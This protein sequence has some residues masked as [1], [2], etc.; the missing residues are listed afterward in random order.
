MNIDFN[1]L[2]KIVEKCVKDKRYSVYINNLNQVIPLCEEIINKKELL[3]VET[4]E[5][6]T[7]YDL[8]KKIELVSS[9]FGTLDTNLKNQFDNLV[10]S[11][12]EDR[13]PT[14]R[15][16]S[17]DMNYAE[18]GKA[19]IK[20]NDDLYDM[21]MILHESLHVMN[22]YNVV[23]ENNNY[24]GENNT[25]KYYGEAV[26]ISAE[27]L[28]GDYLVKNGY[29]T[30][31]DYNILMN[32][33]LISSKCDAKAIIIESV[34]IDMKQA[35]IEINYDNI[36]NYVNGL[37]LSKAK[38]EAV[39]EEFQHGRDIWNILDFNEM[40]FP[41]R[42]RYVIA[43]TLMGKLSTEEL[44]KLNYEVGNPDASLSKVTSFIKK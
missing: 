26:S 28:F 24:I 40:Q 43:Q 17:K 41:V 16:D 4:K 34:L 3:P 6:S 5:Y 30:K 1:K 31:N 33:R 36:K 38:Q 20:V 10:K 44:V 19:F 29:I 12:D 37:E 13:T 7:N 27:K 15:F 11:V 35:G 39:S 25:R 32:N 23:D 2:D 42:Q 22:Y 9:F 8:N 21:F 14:I 18:E